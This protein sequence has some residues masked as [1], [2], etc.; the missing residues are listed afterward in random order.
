MNEA[1]RLGRKLLEVCRLCGAGCAAMSP[2]DRAARMTR[3]Q[4]RTPAEVWR[5][6]FYASVEALCDAVEHSGMA[7]VIDGASGWKGVD[8][9]GTS[10]IGPGASAGTTPR[11]RPA[12]RRSARCCCSSL[13]LSRG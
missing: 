5:A 10:T 8:M 6:R 2:A 4:A 7:N 13:L 3:E 9:S 11:C 12:S 1:E